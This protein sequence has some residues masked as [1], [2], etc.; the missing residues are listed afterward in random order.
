MFLVQATLGPQFQDVFFCVLLPT[1][2]PSS[3]AVL[4]V[5]AV[6]H[7]SISESLLKRTACFPAKKGFFN[8][9]SSSMEF[10]SPDNYR[11]CHLAMHVGHG[12]F[13]C[14]SCSCKDPAA[15]NKDCSTSCKCSGRPN[16][17]SWNLLQDIDLQGQ[18]NHGQN[19]YGNGFGYGSP[20]MQGASLPQA[21]FTMA[22]RYFAAF[23]NS[24]F[25]CRCESNPCLAEMGRG[26]AFFHGNML[27]M[28]RSM[29]WTRY[30]SFWLWQ[31]SK[32]NE[33]DGYLRLGLQILYNP[34]LYFCICLLY[35][36]LDP[37][38]SFEIKKSKHELNIF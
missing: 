32:N 35:Y 31:R 34:N 29:H 15:E 4:A 14:S 13:M 18:P 25:S 2:R 12:I 20:M 11:H 23:C 9:F 38:I 24:I 7:K 19:G 37:R 17:T 10:N 30:G 33:R 26:A 16:L 22:V 6:R 36:I 8:A 1:S 28:A 5:I 27:F 21:S 3:A